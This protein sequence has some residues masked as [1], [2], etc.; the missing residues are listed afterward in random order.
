MIGFLPLVF[1]ESRLYT[2]FK[3]TLYRINMDCKGQAGVCKTSF[4]S[5]IYILDTEASL[6][7]LSFVDALLSLSDNN[8]IETKQVLNNQLSMLEI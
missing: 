8:E 6:H 4:H 1:F 3:N 2:V 7:S 5:V